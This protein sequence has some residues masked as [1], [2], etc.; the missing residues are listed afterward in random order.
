[1]TSGRGLSVGGLVVW[2]GTAA[3]SSIDA[4]S[5]RGFGPP[6]PLPPRAEHAVSVASTTK[7]TVRRFVM[8]R[9]GTLA[10][11]IRKGA[12]ALVFLSLVAC[13]RPDEAQQ[14]TVPPRHRAAPLAPA[15]QAPAGHVHRPGW[16]QGF[17]LRR[18]PH[19]QDDLWDVAVTAPP[20]YDDT[21]PLHLVILAH[22][23]GAN[24]MGWLASGAQEVIPGRPP[25]PG[26]G[27]SCRHDLA[28]TRTLFIAP[29]FAH[30]GPRRWEQWFAR[31]TALREF[32]DELLGEV[33]V[34]RLGR[35]HTVD[36]VATITLMG[37]SAGGYF[38]DSV[39]ARS[40][41]APRVRA[42]VFLDALYVGPEHLV[43][44]ISAAPPGAPRRIVSL[45]GG[46]RWTRGSTEALLAAL[47]PRLRADVAVQARV[48]LPEAIH[49]HAVVIEHSGLEHITMGILNLTKI[50]SGLDLP[51]RASCPEEAP[52][53]T[54]WPGRPVPTRPLAV[55]QTVRDALD[56]RDA[57][58]R[59]GSAA[60]DWAVDL[61]AGVPVTFAVRGEREQGAGWAEL[62]VHAL[63]LRGDDVV[64]ENDDDGGGV[65]SRI[66]VTPTESGRY[67]LRVTSHGP[68]VRAGAYVLEARAGDASPSSDVQRPVVANTT[69]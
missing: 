3:V 1:M 48:P 46:G 38:I 28:R 20:D 65:R 49:A 62:D 23:W 14:R 18:G 31:P 22:G 40:D 59:D 16:A 52:P 21:Q 61:R 66:A 9:D 67:V 11:M 45:D 68:W 35:R 29:Q 39:L 30:R 42:V 60:D 34:A 41:L 69:R 25:I 12:Q 6:P 24:A 54:P 47:P 17:R 32:L 58:L 15:A 4:S 19:L 5:G 44:W 55:G 37:S 64:A 51:R 53:K 57:R 56:A 33:L 63:L 8:A 27:G 2:S 26:W 13:R 43:R 50:L 36:E 10:G 7:E